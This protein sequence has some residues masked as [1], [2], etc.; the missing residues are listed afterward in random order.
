MIPTRDIRNAAMAVLA[1]DVPT[2]APVTPNKM[3]LA[4]NNFNPAEST[5]LSDITEASFDGHTAISLGASPM[6][7]GY[8]PT[9][10]ASKIDL[11]IPAGGFRWRTTGVTNL[12]QTIYGYYLTDSTGAVLLASA[13]FSTPMVLT[14]VNQV[15]D[16]GAPSLSLAPNSI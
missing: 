1:A 2:L 15:I 14:V 12:P 10:D 8:D 9:T 4:Q 6:T 7:E 16:V 5:T 13:K 3:L 11:K